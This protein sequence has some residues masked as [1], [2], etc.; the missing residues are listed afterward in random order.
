MADYYQGMTARIS[1]TFYSAS[2][3]ATDPTGLLLRVRR[4]AR[5]GAA[6][7]TVSVVPAHDS[8]GVYHADVSL[9]AAGPWAYHWE[10]M[11]ASSKAIAEATF[12]VLS[13]MVK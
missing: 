5:N 6:G 8:A 1:A 11:V 2:G 10:G 4:P 3:V 7:P 9:D 12:T 13:P